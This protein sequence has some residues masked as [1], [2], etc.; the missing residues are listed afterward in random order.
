MEDW[1]IVSVKS[2][3]DKKPYN[4]LTD[5][6]IETIADKYITIDSYCPF[7]TISDGSME[8]FARECVQKFIDKT[9]GV[10]K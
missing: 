4:N 8:K 6:E 2:K 1:Q 9:E 10:I 7:C 3:K 5:K